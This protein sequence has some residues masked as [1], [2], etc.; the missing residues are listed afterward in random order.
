[1]TTKVNLKREFDSLYMEVFKYIGDFASLPV[2]PY[3]L[4]Y[5]AFI[6]MDII[7]RSPEGATMNEIVKMEGV[8]KSAIMRHINTLLHENY[9]LQQEDKTDRRI[10]HLMLTQRGQEV[11]VAAAKA[12]DDRFHRWLG[13][14]G[15]K[16]EAQRFVDAVNLAHDRAVAAGFIGFDSLHDKRRNSQQGRDTH[17]HRG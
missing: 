12:M 10:K 7:A 15:G 11:H 2:K 9:I 14:L 16:E 6:V 3:N 17:G 8:S 5:E 13:F 1:M 4:T